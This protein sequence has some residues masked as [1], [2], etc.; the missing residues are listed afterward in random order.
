MRRRVVAHACLLCATLLLVGPAATHAQEL[1]ITPIGGFRVG[2]GMRE[3]YTGSQLDIKDN[4]TYGAIVDIGIPGDRAIELLYSYQGTDL[5]AKGG[6][7]GPRSTD[8]NVHVWQAGLMQEKMISPNLNGY[9]VGSLGLTHFSLDGDSSTRFA[10]G[11]G[12]GLKVFPERRVGLRLDARGYVTFVS[13]SGFYVG[14]GSGGL[15]A[16]FSSDALFQAEFLGG[17]TLRFGS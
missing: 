2:G 17:V 9:G 13:T 8:I 5:T 15:T 3:Y 11:F 14:G 7:I 10:V 12:G 4:W 6:T 16:S 1:S